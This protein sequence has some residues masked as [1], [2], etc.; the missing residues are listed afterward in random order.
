MIEIT[1]LGTPMPKGSKSFKG[2]V[3]GHAVMVE[4]SKGLK[5]WAE[6]VKWAAL[7]H[8]GH[9]TGPVNVQLMF[10]MPKPKS[11]PKRRR[12]FPD[13]KPDLDKLVRA[14]FD[15]LV[16]VGTIEDDARVI[17]LRA[18]KVFPGENAGSLDVP[19]VTISIDEV[20]A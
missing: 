15:A 2:M 10:T 1:V 19:G 17:S 5:P 12:T 8:G 16:A 20:A 4:S 7:E 11:A 18:Y 9:Q 3:N 13:K 14:V 6:A